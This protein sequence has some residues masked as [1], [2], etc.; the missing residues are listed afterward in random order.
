MLG[1]QESCNSIYVSP[2]GL[3]RDLA[4]LEHCHLQLA[5]QSLGNSEQVLSQN[6][7][8]GLPGFVVLLK[9]LISKISATK[10]FPPEVGAQYTRLLL[11]F[12]H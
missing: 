7:L 8:A 5:V 9:H 4:A 3:L 1:L 10:L 2:A 6:A 11:L 12:P